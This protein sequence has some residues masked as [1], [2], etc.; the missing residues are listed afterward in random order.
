MSDTS[1]PE[2]LY[3]ELKHCGVDYS[4]AE[5]AAAYDGNHRQLRDFR[6]EF[7]SMSAF[8]GFSNAPG[9]ANTSALTAL[10]LG[11]G[12]GTT[13]IYLAESF[14]KVWAVDVAE[15]MLALAR[16]KAEKAGLSNLEFVRAGF[17]SYAG[18][19]EPVDFAVIKA[20]F[21]H[22]PD[23]WKQAALLRLNSMLKPG[24]LLYMFDVVFHFAPET[25]AERIP[26]WINGIAA[27]GGATLAAETQTH[28]REEFSTFAWILEGMAFRA[29][30][31][32]AARRNHDDFLTEYLFRKTEDIGRPGR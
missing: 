20:A 3:D 32:V 30:F 31:T 21:H 19:P 12:T 14:K 1:R 18:P 6:G 28:I 13:A 4:D 27:A 16:G 24:G 11:C 26:A 15:P 10:D 9:P 22:L 17:L 8:A 5:L 7:D 23:F 29:G 2:W 25:Y